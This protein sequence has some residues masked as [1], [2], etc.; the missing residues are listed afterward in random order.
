V[1]VRDKSARVA[2]GVAGLYLRARVWRRMWKPACAGAGALLAGA[3]ALFTPL[4][5]CEEVEEGRDS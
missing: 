3:V 4:D 5:G 2:A 1:R